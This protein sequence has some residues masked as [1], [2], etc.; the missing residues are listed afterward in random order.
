LPIFYLDP[1]C[2]GYIVLVQVTMERLGGSIP[3]EN[4]KK[5]DKRTSQDTS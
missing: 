5:T 1:W 3:A 2:C 4:Y